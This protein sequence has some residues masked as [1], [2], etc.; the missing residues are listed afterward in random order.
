MNE[1]RFFIVDDPPADKAP[2]DPCWGV[3]DEDAGG[4]VAYFN[5]PEGAERFE[6]AEN[7]RVKIVV[8]ILHDDFYELEDNDIGTF[9]CWHKRRN[10]GNINYAEHEAYL[11]QVSDKALQIPISIYEH[12]GFVLSVGDGAISCPWDSG[13]VGVWVFEPKDLIE[14][15][16][17][18]TPETRQKAHECVEAIIKYRNDVYSGN[19]WGF[20]IESGD[21]EHIDSCWGF[22]GDEAVT[23]MK[24]HVDEKYHKALDEAWENRY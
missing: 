17:A 23:D 18:D 24:E 13:Y 2:F 9:V 10:L 3:A 8:K 22:V 7:E 15:W 21:G 16:G 1:S 12:G 19:V 11:D 6:R 20:S 4:I 14:H 5:S